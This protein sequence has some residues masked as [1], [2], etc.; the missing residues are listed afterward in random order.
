MRP[1]TNRARLSRSN[2][3]FKITSCGSR[4]MVDHRNRRRYRELLQETPQWNAELKVEQ[5]DDG[6]WVIV[7]LLPS[8]WT[9]GWFGLEKNTLGNGYCWDREDEARQYLDEHEDELRLEL[10]EDRS[11]W[12]CARAAK[13]SYPRSAT[14]SPTHRPPCWPADRA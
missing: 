9:H 11:R 12:R 8:R 10:A 5:D 7:G 3:R 14:T 2:V 4:R 6:D 1:P 13:T